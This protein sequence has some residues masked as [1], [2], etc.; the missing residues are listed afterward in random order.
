MNA[1]RVDSDLLVI[2]LGNVERGDDAIGV[3]LVQAVSARSPERVEWRE[4]G[5]SD[6]LSMAH[7][8]LEVRC[9]VLVVD[10]ARMG[11]RPG[12]WRV[13]DEESVRFAR[14]GQALSTHGIGFDDALRLARTLGFDQPL[15]FFA[16]QVENLAPGGALSQALAERF[17]SLTKALE[18]TIDAMLTG[19][20][21]ER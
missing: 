15:R 12:K 6:A 14:A 18:N 4:W 3:R 16:V 7:D 21:C 20:A 19:T 8:L 10:G 1:P 2:G 5:D 17:D 11:A 13:F 9:P